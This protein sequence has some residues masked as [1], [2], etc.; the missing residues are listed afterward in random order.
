MT[1]VSG[2][3][4][5]LFL[6]ANAFFVAAEFALVASSRA[7][8]EVLAEGG[9][10]RARAALG[11]K[12][13]LRVQLAGVQL[14]NTMASLG[15]GFLVEPAVA[16]LMDPLLGG[17]GRGFSVTVSIAIVV[18]LHVLFGELVPKNAALS[19]P[20]ALM[21]WLAPALRLFVGTFRPLIWGLDKL[22]SAGARLCGVRPSE[23]VEEPHGPEDISG[24]L[25]ES[26]GEGLIDE[27]EHSLLTASLELGKRPVSS[28]MVPRSE[29]VGI[30]RGATAAEAERLVVSSG[31]SRLLVGDPD[32]PDGFVHAKDLLAFDQKM[33]N[34][35][36][37]A[38]CIR[39]ALVFPA[40]ST[41]E[42]LLLQMR[43]MR[44]HLAIIREDS[45][46]VGLLT[47]EDVLELLVGEIRDESD[48]G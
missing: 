40:D 29:I 30:P 44:V 23:M 2:L 15:L 46:T 1:A 3:L 16:E 37:S 9:N 27:F 47:L 28:A 42:E 38:S 14:G 13:N 10:R 33:M 22:A 6:G 31:H 20:D 48:V 39:R 4:A 5:I 18:V 34:A 8:L 12:R 17:V 21:M 24:M 25:A 7:R 36:V 19:R 32:R 41:L 26:R 45:E 11:A 35:P 43:R